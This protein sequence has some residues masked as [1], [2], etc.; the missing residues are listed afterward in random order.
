LGTSFYGQPS[1][2][3]SNSKVPIKALDNYQSTFKVDWDCQQS[4]MQLAKHNKVQ[5][6]WVPGYESMAGN[7]TAD[8][9]ANWDLNLY[10]K[11]LNQLAS[12]QW[13][14]PRKWSRTGQIDHRK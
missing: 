2:I 8:Q 9:M 14:F 11:D 3:L 13:E 6:I 10:S 4:L 5:L 1:Y 7:E 12:P